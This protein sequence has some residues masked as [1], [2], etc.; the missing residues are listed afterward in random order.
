MSYMTSSK[1]EELPTALLSLR[2]VADLDAG[3]LPRILHQFQNLN[4]IPRR[5]FAE[6]GST[7][8]LYIRIDVAGLP[9]ER[10][11]LIAAKVAQ[12]AGVV[13]AYW[14]RF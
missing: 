9:E 10:L 1:A 7:P 13:N 14:H 2:V 8:K 3:A 5:V 4:V 11:S 12:L 6:L